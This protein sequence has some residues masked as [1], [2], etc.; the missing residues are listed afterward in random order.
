MKKKFVQ[1]V[2]LC[3]GYGQRLGK[4]TQNIPK[5]LIKVNGKPFIEY[6]INFLKKFG[7]NKFLLLCKYQS[8]K[9][10]SKYKNIKGIK[11]VSEKVKMNTGGALLNSIKKLDEN[12]LFYNGDTFADFNF[13]H[14]IDHLKNING[15]NSIAIKLEKNPNRFGK[16]KINGKLVTKID[17]NLSSKFIFSGFALLNKNSI[18]NIVNEKKNF[19]ELI[20]SDLINKKKLFFF[21]INKNT[22]FIDIGTVSDLKASSKIINRSKNRKAVFFDRDGTINKDTGY[23]YK[24]EDFIWNKSFF[25]TIKFLNSNNILAIVISNQSGVGRGYYDEKDVLKLHKWMNEVLLKKGS[26]IDD[27]FYAIFYKNSKK[28]RFNNSHAILRKPRTGMILKAKKKWKL[29]LNKA[30]II[31][32]NDVDKLLAKK[33]NIK[34][35]KVN[36]KSNLLKKIKKMWNKI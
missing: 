7:F 6:Q 19:E 15:K 31:G 9:F 1:A 29:N 10:M 23:L 5:P 27:F 11:I 25:K 33:L 16:V 12:F 22:N 28:Y 20:L 8:H 26:Y 21:K 18:K 17:K 14:F 30:I 4:I 24:K 34:F 32:D 36:Y 13:N 35:I 2:I 3:G